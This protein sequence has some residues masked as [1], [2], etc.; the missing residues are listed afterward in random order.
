MMKAEFSIRVFGIY[1]VG[2]GLV[3]ILAPNLIL[4]PFG[5]EPAVTVWP[6]VVGVLAAIIGFYYL[7]AALTGNRDLIRWSLAGRMFAVFAFVLFVLVGLSP[8]ALILFAVVDL[9]AAGWTWMSLNRE[10]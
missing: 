5:F 7:M 2:I 1:L 6:R 4:V 9:F 3:L 8:P 10:S